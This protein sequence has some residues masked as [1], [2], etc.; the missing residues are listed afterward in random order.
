MG[1]HILTSTVEL[2]FPCCWPLQT[3]CWI[4]PALLWREKGVKKKPLV[5]CTVVWFLAKRACWQKERFPRQH[6]QRESQSGAIKLYNCLLFPAE[7]WFTL[8]FLFYFFRKKVRY[9][10]SCLCIFSP[11]FKQKQVYCFSC[12]SADRW[13]VLTLKGRVYDWTDA[14]IYF[15]LCCYSFEKLVKVLVGQQL[16]EK[17]AW[18]HLDKVVGFKYR[19][20]QNC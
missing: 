16:F 13:R 19:F 15:S 5:V 4:A 14:K 20:L 1:S 11:L 17:L 18:T 12:W 7:T 6:K 3:K 2:F 9:S 10:S 8:I